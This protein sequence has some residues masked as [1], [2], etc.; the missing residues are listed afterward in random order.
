VATPVWSVLF[1]L[2]AGLSLG[3]SWLLV[4]RLE[5][6]GERLGLS[7]AL[8]GVVAALAA[9]APEIT[10]AVT[11][12]LHHDTGVGAGVVLGSNVFNLAALLGLGAMVAGKI[13]L[14]RRVVLLSGA[15]A[16]WVAAGCL[17]TTLG[18]VGPG[19]GLLLVCAVLVPYVALLG[20]NRERLARLPLP[21]AWNRWLADAVH[22]EEREL[23]EAIAPTRGTWRD[24]AV[25]V[26]ALVLVL[27]ASV[28]M[29]QAATTVGT[30]LGMAQ[31]IT[32]G[33]ALAIVTSLPNAV[34]AVYLAARGR[35][36]AVLST[37][38]TSNALNVAV[39]LLLPGALLG[40]GPREGTGIL[41]AAWY[42]GL[43]I[44]ALLFA[45]ADRGLRR[46]EG[47]FIIT[48]YLVFV[49]VL[50]AAV[51]T[52]I[53]RTPLALWP[54][55]GFALVCAGL[56]AARRAG[57]AQVEGS[58]GDGS[59]P[60][61]SGR[62][63]LLPGW[64]TTRIWQTSLLLSLLVAACDAATG[65]H[66]ILIGALIVGPCCALLTGRWVPTALA[67]V[68][69][70]GLGTLTAVPDGIWASAEQFTFLAAVAAV[71]VVS[72]LSAG[73]IQRLRTTARP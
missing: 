71:T 9:D 6:L 31:I 44:A 38:L 59:G 19:I 48:G 52:G 67:G 17:L 68:W 15:V 42:T 13:A 37:A 7:E 50:L 28:T 8:L 64:T 21:A 29:E 4:V 54:A 23:D 27:G 47:V 22:E 43:T 30:R 14:H 3:A 57:S 46:S 55:L 33:L 69:A 62:Q 60:G 41:V 45:Y 20:V 49:A 72:T 66:L 32:G 36:A 40:L 53:I 10:S 18:V 24:G 61:R 11:A 73:L 34:A 16:V 35:G 2:G 51:H 65:R 5:R 25:A 63:S 56:L 12:L 58:D 70:L 39:G 26:L 1:V